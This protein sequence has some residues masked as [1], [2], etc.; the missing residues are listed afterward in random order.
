[1]RVGL[2]ESER[3]M[4]HRGEVE[5]LQQRP[6]LPLQHVLLVVAEIEPRMLLQDP[7]Q[8]VE[9]VR[10]HGRSPRTSLAAAA[11][12]P[13]GGKSAAQAPTAAAAPGM[14]H[15][16]L[17]ASSCAITLPPASAML[18]APAAPSWPMPVSTTPSDA[19]PNVAATLLNRG[20]TA[21][22][23]KCTGGSSPMRKTGAVGFITVI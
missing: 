6:E 9:L 21:G 11:A 10:H 15:T 7:A 8:Q 18:R 12:M 22:R 1:M 13:A 19:A 5:L 16:T 20:S 3:E 23:Q 17:E 2:H 14:P 4:G